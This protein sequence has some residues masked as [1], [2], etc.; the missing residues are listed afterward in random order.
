MSVRYA[1][2]STPFSNIQ[3]I[4]LVVSRSISHLVE[5]S[6]VSCRVYLIGYQSI[7]SFRHNIR[8]LTS[9][10][11]MR[12]L[13]RQANNSGY[14]YQKHVLDFVEAHR[15]EQQSEKRRLLPPNGLLFLTRV[16]SVGMTVD[17]DDGHGVMGQNSVWVYPTVQSSD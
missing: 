16:E 11:T 17:Q 4:L 13:I 14:Q 7:S 5:Q 2:L 6:I 12:V 3:P 8:K 15:E 10:A 1:L 9:Q